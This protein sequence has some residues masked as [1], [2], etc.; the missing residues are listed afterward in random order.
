MI[1]SV[2]LGFKTRWASFRTLVGSLT[3]DKTWAKTTISKEES[4]RGK[5]LDLDNKICL[6]GYCDF[7]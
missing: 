7:A 3:T 6:L 2:P 4:A 5:R 1:M